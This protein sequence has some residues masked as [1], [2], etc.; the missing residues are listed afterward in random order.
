LPGDLA[1]WLGIAA[2]A[3]NG[4]AVYLLFRPDALAWFGERA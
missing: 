2:L 4:V 3:L 1:G